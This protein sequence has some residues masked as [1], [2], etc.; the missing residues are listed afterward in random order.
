MTC[1]GGKA[2]HR[3]ERFG[4]K[5]TTLSGVVF[6]WVSEAAAEAAAAEAVEAAEAHDTYNNMSAAAAA[7]VGWCKLTPRDTDTSNTSD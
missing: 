3:T 7:L 5:M 2:R 4:G 6:R 1:P